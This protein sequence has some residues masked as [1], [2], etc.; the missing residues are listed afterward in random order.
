MT[1]TIHEGQPVL[2]A[3]VPLAQAKTALILL[4]GRGSNAEDILSLAQEIGGAHVAALAPQAAGN[5]WYPLR[6]IEPIE[7]NEP[8]L[9][10]A[11]GVVEALVAY[12]E[13][14]GISAERI[15]IG[16]FSQGA[17][18]ASEYV[19]RNARRYGGLLVF[20]GGL[21]GNTV[22]VTR[23]PGTL[24]GTPVFI[25]CDPKDF[26]IPLERVQET[27]AQFRAMGAVVDERI[28]RDL[29]HTINEEELE[30]ARGIIAGL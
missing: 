6:F 26:H 11:L 2:A 23:Y 15:I 30:A 19:A 12:V 5:S 18:L 14:Q 22:D 9:S 10:S 1:R 7:R 27:S 21:I 29:G 4:H 24:S 28:Y 3:G 17:C 8:Y 20:S 13:A 16:G 25:G